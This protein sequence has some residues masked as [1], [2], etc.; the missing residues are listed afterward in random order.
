MSPQNEHELSRGVFQKGLFFKWNIL[1]FSVF[2]E[3]LK[4]TKGKLRSPVVGNIFVVGFFHKYFM[5]N[6]ELETK[7]VS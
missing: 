2:N 1:D 4:N 3:L 6:F 7:I 5:I